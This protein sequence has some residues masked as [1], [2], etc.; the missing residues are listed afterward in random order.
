MTE[1]ALFH[2]IMETAAAPIV[3]L[4]SSFAFHYLN[5]EAEALWGMTTMEVKGRPFFGERFQG[6]LGEITFETLK[7]ALSGVQK[8]GLGT[9]IV[10]PDGL[11]RIILWN[12]GR[13]GDSNLVMVGMDVTGF[14]KAEEALREREARMSSIIATAP[15]AIVTIDENGL[16]QSFS[17]AAQVMFGYA[18]GEVVGRNISILMPLPHRLE[19]DNYI[20]RYIRTEERHIIG[21][22]RKIEA[23][24]KDGTVFP[25]EL[26][27]GEVR[28]GNTRIFTGF[29]RDLTARVQMEEE[30]RQVQKMEA[31]GQLTGGV[32]HDF[33][34]ILTVIGGNLE[35]LERKLTTDEQRSI[36]S[37]AQEATQL[38][39]TLSHR[40]LAFG[41]RQ[42]LNPKPIDLSALVAGMVDLL[43]R[44]LGTAVTV[45]PRLQPNLP[46]T[47]ADP[48]QIENALL[49][50]AINARDAMP[51]GGTLTLET[52]EAVLDTDYSA[53]HP[54][55]QGGRYVTLFVTDNGAGMSPEVKARAFD[56]FFTTKGP[57]RG[58]G[59]GLSSVYGLV[60]QS[61]GNIHLFSELGL[62]TTI[63][64]FLPTADAR[65]ATTDEVRSVLS[66]P[67]RGATVLVVEDDPRVRKVSIRR[68]S[69][70]GYRV[71]EAD[72][73]LCAL[74][75]FEGEPKI[76]ILFTD[77]MMPGGLSGIDLAQAVTERWPDTKILLTSGYADPGV[78]GKSDYPWIGKPYNTRQLAKALREL[79]G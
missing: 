61:G 33:N 64:I 34:N 50:L 67:P 42:P 43:Q 58:T 79:M 22:G 54:N 62:G 29:I 53:I 13:A 2:G 31:I 59:L 21:I 25:V 19:H 65:E 63:K 20:A 70:M 3:I 68:I 56:P 4:T 78:K 7:D 55:M 8:R 5:P 10:H 57:G 47:I 26:A 76:D 49:N 23:Q 44:T 30:L 48:G 77:I 1:R 74:D 24:H 37:E 41:R 6:D 35:F 52:A 14:H 72:R 75:V 36:V 28:V 71:L 66:A 11:E 15:D 45:E 38:G 73:V 51:N 12:I 17:Q 32:A 18:A 60:K 27:V 39:A 16:I 9:R 40:L 46:L 69:E